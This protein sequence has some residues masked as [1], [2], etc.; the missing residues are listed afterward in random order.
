MDTL[1]N[2]SKTLSHLSD[3]VRV[4]RGF[5]LPG[6]GGERV[7]FLPRRLLVSLRLVDPLGDDEGVGSGF[8]GCLVAGE[9]SLAVLDR[10]ALRVPKTPSMTCDVQVCAN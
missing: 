5:L 4:E 7:E 8:E 10:L 1:C 3:L 2:V 6:D 9:S